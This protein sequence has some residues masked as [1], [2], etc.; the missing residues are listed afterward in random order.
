MPREN[1]LARIFQLHPE[2][3]QLTGFPYTEVTSDLEFL[4]GREKILSDSVL[5]TRKGR[6]IVNL[7]FDPKYV[8]ERQKFFKRLHTSWE[9]KKRVFDKPFPGSRNL[10]AYVRNNA[11]F[12]LCQEIEE[13]IRD[14]ST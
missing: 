12:D 7:S 2:R 10:K 6:K 5:G 1:S 13:T 11:F 4:M 9:T 14:A 8:L 3:I